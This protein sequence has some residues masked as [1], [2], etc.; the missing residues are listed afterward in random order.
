[1]PHTLFK[2]AFISSMIILMSAC[3][4]IEH[5]VLGE[6]GY[7]YKECLKDSMRGSHNFS[8]EDVRQLC[9]EITGTN[10]PHYEIKDD[11]MVPSNEFTRCYEIQKKILESKGYED[12]DETAKLICK[13]AP[14]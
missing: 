3:E 14:N 9:E 2:S 11:K 8:A 1:M 12:A 5:E 4:R 10:T 13:Y 7:S 6:P